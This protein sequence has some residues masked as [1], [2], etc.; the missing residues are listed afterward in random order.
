LALVGHAS[1]KRLVADNTGEVLIMMQQ[2]LSL[3][4][5]EINSIAMMIAVA[6]ALLGGILW[7]GGSR[8]SRTLMTLIS[9]FV[10]ALIGLQLPNWFSLGLEGWAT[11]VLGALVLGISG[12]AMHKVWVG[13][14]LG[15]VLAAWAAVATFVVC[16]DPKGFTW[17]VSLE[18]ASLHVRLM[19]IWN[20]LSP[21]VRR[22]LPFAV[23]AGLISGV[24][25]SLLWQRLGVVLLYSSAGVTLLVGLG[26][27]VLNSARHEWLSVIPK[28][29]SSQVI[30]LICLVAFGAILQWRVAPGGA[31]PRAA[32]RG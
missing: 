22:L 29:T 10:G 13:L 25:A 8:F 20:S 2:L 9:V 6:G 21:D 3:M 16:G 4:P 14:G 28:Q 15:L 27:A 26:V 24:C 18:G 7:L 5:K 1:R 31:A 11:A 12:Y 17:P 30:M 23:C 32:G 19:D